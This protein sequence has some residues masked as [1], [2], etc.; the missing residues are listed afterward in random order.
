MANQYEDDEDDMELEEQV[1]PDS[2]GPANLRKALKRAE[3]EKNELA[4]QLADIQSDLRNR[5]V[6]DVLA[7]K[8]V[9]DKVAK[10]IPGDI[11]TPEQIDAWLQENAD[12]FGFSKTE[13]DAAPISEEEQANRASYQRINAAT[14]N[15]DTPSRDADLMAKLNGAKSIDELNAITGNPTQRRR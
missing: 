14:Q 12:V 3:K 4:K 10:F 2:N 1:Q 13:S 5:S 7:T 9:P 8:G 6:K 11:T 15:A